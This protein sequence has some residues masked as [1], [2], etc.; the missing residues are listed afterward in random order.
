[1]IGNWRDK[2]ISFLIEFFCSVLRVVFEGNEGIKLHL[3]K[4][5]KTYNFNQCV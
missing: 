3:P 1:M 4:Y 2:N 5:Y